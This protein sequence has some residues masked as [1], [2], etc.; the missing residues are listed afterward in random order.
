MLRQ[1]TALLL[2]WVGLAVG[3]PALACSLATA[4]KDCCPEGATISKA[5]CAAASVSPAAALALDANRILPVSTADTGSPDP[6]IVLAA[7]ATSFTDALRVTIFT[8]PLLIP[9]RTDVIPTYLT[10]GRLRL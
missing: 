9:T 3:T 6:L 2:V 10:T 1:L 8:G 5:C 4:D 7:R